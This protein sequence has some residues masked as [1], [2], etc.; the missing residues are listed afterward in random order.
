MKHFVLRVSRGERNGKMRNG[1]KG[2]FCCR[3]EIVN[4]QGLV[5]CKKS[6]TSCLGVHAKDA[7]MKRKV[8]K[9]IILHAQS[10]A[11]CADTTT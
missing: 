6:S 11:E 3:V 5:N 2:D 9:A 4:Y 8:R 7:K 10:S 1:R